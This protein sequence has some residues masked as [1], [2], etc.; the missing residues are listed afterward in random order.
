MDA[1]LVFS[2]ID[3]SGMFDFRVGMVNIFDPL[4]LLEQLHFRSDMRRHSKVYMLWLGRFSFPFP[5]IESTA[6][7]YW[8]DMILDSRDDYL[9]IHILWMQVWRMKFR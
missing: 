4:L 6:E 7:V 1:L 5:G 3:F 9:R 8:S 2:H